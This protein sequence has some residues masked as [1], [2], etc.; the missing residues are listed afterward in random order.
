M[1]DLIGG[2]GEQPAKQEQHQ[3]RPGFVFDPT[4]EE[5]AAMSD[6]TLLDVL[7]ALAEYDASGGKAL[8]KV[9]REFR[10]RDRVKTS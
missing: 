4:P 3:A 9:R 1:L 10:R 6:D 8:R 5:I 2:S 7:A